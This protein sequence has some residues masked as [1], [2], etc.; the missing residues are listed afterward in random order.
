MCRRNGLEGVDF[1]I[2]PAARWS[3]FGFPILYLA[4][5]VI[6][7][8]KALGLVVEEG[9]MVYSA[10][11]FWPDVIPAL[12][13]KRRSRGRWLAG[14]YMCAPAPWRKDCPY[15]GVRR[16]TGLFYWL[17][18]K[19]AFWVVKRYADLVSVT[20]QP[21]V[22]RFVTERRGADKVIVLRGGVNVGATRE[23]MRR[24]GPVPLDKKV[25]D[26]CFVG[27]F[28]PQK[29]VSELVDIWGKVCTQK[30]EAQLAMIGDGPL[31]ALVRKKIETREL[32]RNIS[33]LGFRDGEEKLEIFRQ[34]KIIVHP[35]VFDSGGMAAC[36]G[37]ACGLVG[38]GFDLPALSTYYPKG[39]VKVDC[40]DQD[41]FAASILKLMSD[42][43]LY[44]RMQ[45][46]AIEW[47]DEWD[48]DNRAAAVLKRM[49]CLM[50]ES[51]S[52]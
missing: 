50:K 39:M 33:L 7:C 25:Y 5:T 28:H 20:S 29:G 10:S 34:S 27:R 38:V 35:A 9:S 15:K 52:G 19:P 3:G 8:I 45:R 4:R 31:E 41:Q 30:P 46:E 40:F 26:A 22:R 1:T 48:W 32:D 14:F 11:D 2:W 21:D 49:R 12:V 6:G 43:G 23:Y 17:T 24:R 18:Q 47:A 42:A 37:M 16:L 51:K 44:D 36:E 13:L